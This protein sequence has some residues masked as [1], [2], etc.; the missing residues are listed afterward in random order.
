MNKSIVDAYGIAMNCNIAKEEAVKLIHA[1][2]KWERA[3]RPYGCHE[4]DT[5]PE[6]A[7]DDLIQAAADRQDAMNSIDCRLGLDKSA[8]QQK[9]KEADERSEKRLYGGRA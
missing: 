1:I 2:L 5:T 7:K 3:A 9:I 4:T 8:I 6:E